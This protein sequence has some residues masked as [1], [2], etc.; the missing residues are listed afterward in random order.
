MDPPTP[1]RGAY[2]EGILPRYTY[3]ADGLIIIEGNGG[4]IMALRYTP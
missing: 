2:S 4:E 3:V 1:P